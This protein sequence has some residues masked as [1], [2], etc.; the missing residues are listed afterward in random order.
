MTRVSAEMVA[1]VEQL[2]ADFEARMHLPREF[3]VPGETRVSASLE[4][5]RTIL[6]RAERRAVT[7]DRAGLVPGPHLIPYLNRLADLLWVLARTAEQAESRLP[8]AARAAPAPRAP[9]RLSAEASGRPG[10][11]ELEASRLPEA[12]LVTLHPR[13]EN[14]ELGPPG[15]DRPGVTNRTMMYN[16]YAPPSSIGVRP[17]A[18]L[19]QAFLTQ[20]FT[21]MFLGLLLTTVVGGVASG[22]A[23]STLHGLVIPV[24]VGQVGLA[25]ALGF[26]LR[27]MP[28]TVG[29]LLFFV[30]AATMGVTLAVILKVYSLGSVVAAGSSAAAVFGGAAFYA[31][32]TKRDLTRLGG[33]LFMALIGLLVAM[34]V[35]LFI[36]WTW[37]SFGISVAGVVIFTAPD[38]LRRPADPERRRRGVGRVDG[39]G[40]R[41]G[42]V[43]PLPR[44]HQPVL[45]AAPAVRELARL[46]TGCLPR[47]GRDRAGPGS[48][49]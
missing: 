13:H 49:S 4:V 18:R 45:H 1:G 16:R 5:A 19:A 33:Y 15:P 24:I 27:S 47:P 2:L 40:R 11:G 48:L 20:A 39:E 32:V 34:V 31:A 22:F 30:Y 25:L 6:R 8:M 17:D 26:G 23:T 37:L 36:G 29:L 10:F 28:A 44:L 9:A 3:V 21:F 46:T 12:L 41:H 42:R 7:L 14:H 35:N 38:R 43:P